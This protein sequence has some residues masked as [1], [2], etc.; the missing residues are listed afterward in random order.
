MEG[1]ENMTQEQLQF[2]KRMRQLEDSSW[3][4]SRFIF[5][6]FLNEAEYSDVLSMGMSA[7]GMAAYGGYESAS[8]V[9]IRFGDPDTLGYKE[10]FPITILHISPRMEKFADSLT[11][12]DF[13][14][15]ILNLGIDRRVIGDILIDGKAA[16]V[17]CESRMA[18]YVLEKLTRVKHTSV[19][20]KTVDTIPDDAG[21]KAVGQ[22]VQV[23]SNRIDAVVAQ[24]Y[25]FSRSQ[26][27]ELLQGGQ[28]FMNGRE[29]QNASV[30]L[31]ENDAVSVRHHGKFRFAGVA[32]ETKK[33]NLRIRIERYV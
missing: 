28:V 9:M 13:L 12:R 24:V 21:P 15:A 14:G 5:T 10:P 17:M 32:G 2:Q 16:Y 8:R 27:Q 33:G 23:S 11:H 31:R 4:E 19:N 26:A 22:N 29:V 20:V 25:H 7:G 30:Q 6:D 18:E 1:A 3:Q